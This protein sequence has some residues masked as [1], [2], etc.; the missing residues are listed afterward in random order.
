MQLLSGAVSSIPTWNWDH[1]ALC[2]EKIINVSLLEGDRIGG[3]AIVIVFQLVDR[4][5]ITSLN[6]DKEWDFKQLFTTQKMLRFL[7]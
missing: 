5:Y 4:I 2:R 3:K 6:K 1:N 7:M